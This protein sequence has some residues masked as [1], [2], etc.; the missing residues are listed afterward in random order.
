M[1]AACRHW[2]GS[3]PSSAATPRTA[4]TISAMPLA[5]MLTPF[6]V[7]NSDDAAQDTED[8]SKKHVPENIRKIELATL[9]KPCP[10]RKWQQSLVRVSDDPEDVRK[11]KDSANRVLNMLKAALNLAYQNGYAHTD[12]AW[13]SVSSP[14]GMSAQPGSCS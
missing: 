11:S 1:S 7:N 6:K 13:R 5:I 3:R 4:I 12:A 2:N 9:T 14:S 8:G 10:L